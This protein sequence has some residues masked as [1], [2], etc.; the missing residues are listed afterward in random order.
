MAWA[1][2][3]LMSVLLLLTGFVRQEEG[4]G[5]VKIGP[6]QTNY[7]IP[8]PALDSQ[9]NRDPRLHTVKM[10]QAAVLTLGSV[11][12]LASAAN[13]QLAQRLAPRSEKAGFIFAALT[14]P[15]TPGLLA[16]LL[17]MLMLRR[18]P[19]RDPR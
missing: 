4:R 9:S 16:A 19:T 2:Y 8:I 18:T 12:P 15:G 5:P 11:N 7:Q 3:A 10:E 13:L 17:S 6:I 1:P 14:T